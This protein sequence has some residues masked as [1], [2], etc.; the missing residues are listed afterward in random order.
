MTL[1]TAIEPLLRLASYSL[2][3]G[4]MLLWEHVSGA[5]PQHEKL[6]RWASNLSL[7]WFSTLCIRLFIP[8]GAVALAMKVQQQQFGLLQSLP[9]PLNVA[10]SVLVLDLVIYWQHRAFHAF[11]PLWRIHA[12]HHLDTELDAS[13]GGRFH[14][15]EYIISMLIKML[16]VV[17]LGCAPVAVLAFEI[18]LNASAIFNHAN[19]RLPK[20]LKKLLSPW[21]VIPEVHR[22]HHSTKHGQMNSNFGFFLNWW[23]KLFDSFIHSEAAEAEVTKIGI[24]KQNGRENRSLVKL[25]LFPFKYKP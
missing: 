16:T 12:T 6:K 22:I 25:L 15:I 5:Y 1:A 11:T 14:P 4:G 10:V 13:T 8:L 18:I 9:L 24:N 17:M 2:V 20:M 19:V 7:A 23:D 3:L 21:L